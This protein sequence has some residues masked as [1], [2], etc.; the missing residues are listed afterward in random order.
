M[1]NVLI[2]DDHQLLIDDLVMLTERDEFV[3]HE[4]IAHL[5]S[6]LHHDPK[7]VVV[8]GGGDGG[9]VRELV[10]HPTIESIVLCE[11]DE[12]H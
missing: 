11:I 1:K 12:L 7:K 3:Y 2:A 9:T 8:I 5:P 6:L 4:I 10:R